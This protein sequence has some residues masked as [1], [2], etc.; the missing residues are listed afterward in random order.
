MAHSRSHALSETSLG[1][2][3]A[4]LPGGSLQQEDGKKGLRQHVALSSDVGSVPGLPTMW[5]ASVPWFSIY[6]LL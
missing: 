3:G 2:N 1:W 5:A 6:G 4:E